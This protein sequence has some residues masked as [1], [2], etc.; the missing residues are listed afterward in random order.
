MRY[1]T[2][3]IVGSPNVGKSTIFNRIIG[4]RESIINNERG[5]TRDRIYGNAEWLTRQFRVIDTG[6]IEL[7][8]HPFQ[9]QIRMQAEIAIH[10]ADVIL[11]IVDGKTGLTG[12]DKLVAKILFKA[13]KPVVLAVNKIDGQDQLDSLND[14]YALGLGDPMPISG[15]HGIGVGDVL[16]KIIKLLP[17]KKE[18]I[19]ENAITFAVIGRPNV[20]KSSLVNALLNESRVIVSPLEG[21]TRDAIDTE[22]SHNEVN[23]VAIDTAGLKKR[24]QIYEAIDKYSAIRALD[25]IDRAKICLLVIDANEGIKEQDKHV[26]SYATDQKKAVVIV[27]N[28]WDLIEKDDKTMNEF[29]KK[30]REQF[31]FLTYAPIVFVS[32]KNKTRLETLFRAIEMANSAY[33]IRIPTSVLNE[34]IQDAQVMNEAPDFNGGR[35]RI[36]FAN[37]TECEPPTIVMFVNKPRYAHFSYMRYI[38]NRLRESFALDGTPINIIL[39]E[40]V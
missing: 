25:A 31:Q 6:G 30:V 16:D 11:F 20:G 4:H 21:T 35:L 38:E 23:Y 2:L 29:I 13:K 15:A 18:K 39:R 1:G 9:E 26:V 14:F 34:V 10:E 7:A 24:G 22:F 27:V 36:Y 8:N 37:Q 40:R 17:V 28:K 5:V 12:D 19:Y 33:N 32:A 3:A